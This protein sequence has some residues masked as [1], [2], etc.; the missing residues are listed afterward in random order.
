MKPHQLKAISA[1]KSNIP[2]KAKEP[3]I[4]I[5]IKMLF[6]CLLEKI[7]WRE[8]LLFKVQGHK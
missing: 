8:G 6:N 2:L 7:S 5:E 4:F 1:L 3:E